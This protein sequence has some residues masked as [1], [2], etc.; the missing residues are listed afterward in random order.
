MTAARTAGAGSVCTATIIEINSYDGVLLLN[1]HSDLYFLFHNFGVQI[2]PFKTRKKD[3]AKSPLPRNLNYDLENND[4]KTVLS[5]RRF[6]LSD[7]P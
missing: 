2:I 1:E 5:R 3:I 4:S 6:K 7:F